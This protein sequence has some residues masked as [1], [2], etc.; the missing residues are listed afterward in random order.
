MFVLIPLD[1]YT[2]KVFETG[3]LIE[4]QF[5]GTGSLKTYRIFQAACQL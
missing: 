1:N 4:L 2:F 3:I 5:F